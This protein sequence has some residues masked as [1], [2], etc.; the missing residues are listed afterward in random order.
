MGGYFNLNLE[1]NE[2]KC[3][4]NASFKMENKCSVLA[5]LTAY[6]QNADF[7]QLI[8]VNKNLYSVFYRL[9]LKSLLNCVIF[10]IIIIA[11]GNGR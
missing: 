9:A 8:V 6:N 1:C 10:M 4:E 5:M 2:N 3:L 7:P 11:H